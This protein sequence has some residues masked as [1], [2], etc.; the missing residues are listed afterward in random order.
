MY[1]QSLVT[2]GHTGIESRVILLKI[3]KKMKFIYHPSYIY[4]YFHKMKI[5]L[6]P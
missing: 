2:F 5:L 3:L 6:L 1:I 4:W